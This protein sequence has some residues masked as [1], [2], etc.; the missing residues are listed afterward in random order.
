MK[1][2]PR[3]RRLLRRGFA[4]PLVVMLAMAGTLLVAVMLDRQSGQTLMLGRQ[5][6]GV[7]A[8]HFQRGLREI[9]QAWVRNQTRYARQM[10]LRAAIDPDGRIGEISLADGTHI[11][12]YVFEGQGTARRGTVGL[13]RQERDDAQTVLDIL[14]PLSPQEQK[15]Q[16]REHGPVAVSIFSAP[17]ETL[18]AIVD[19][20]TGGE[21][22]GDVLEA[23]LT[24]RDD[25]NVTTNGLAKPEITQHLEDGK[26]EELQRLLTM[27]PRLWEV[28]LEADLGPDFS[29]VPTRARYWGLFL[30]P[31]AR[32]T[33]TYERVQVLTWNSIDLGPQGD[34]QTVEQ[35]RRTRDQDDARRR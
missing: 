23:I 12:L 6:E 14:G 16:T 33:N 20:V 29:A 11:V 4:L 10:P 30:L 31:D 5:V 2:H 7:R 19:H 26:A 34:G 32:R 18:A 9:I 8:F 25:P 35:W 24:L 13:N 22:S 15:A 28:V 21:H 3:S 17:V 27:T 1:R